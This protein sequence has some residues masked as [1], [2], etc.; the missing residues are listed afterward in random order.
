MLNF[1]SNL[2]AGRIKVMSFVCAQWIWYGILTNIG[3]THSDRHDLEWRLCKDGAQT[4][5]L[6]RVLPQ[7]RHAG[8]GN[9]GDKQDTTLLEC[10]YDPI[11]SL[12]PF[13][14][15]FLISGQLLVIHPHGVG[16]FFVFLR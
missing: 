1:D 15:C 14:L 10:G 6:L 16:P 13:L 5:V 4:S 7:L 12:L 8:I 11:V 3:W 9:T 2:H